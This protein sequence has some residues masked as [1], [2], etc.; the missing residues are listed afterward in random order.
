M[1]GLLPH[2][3]VETRLFAKA[4]VA[5]SGSGIAEGMK[6]GA[7]RLEAGH[8]HAIDRIGLAE[9]HCLVGDVGDGAEETHRAVAAARLTQSG[10]VSALSLGGLTP[11]RGPPGVADSTRGAGRYTRPAVELRVDQLKR[12]VKLGILTEADI[13]CFARQ[14]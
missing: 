8:S 1:G 3:A 2:V 12:L 6:V 14:Q 9:C 7:A 11:H 13:G 10:R 5:V 4:L